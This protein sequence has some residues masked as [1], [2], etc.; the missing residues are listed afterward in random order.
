MAYGRGRKRSSASRG[1]S[2]YSARRTTRRRAPV[3]RRVSRGRVRKSGTARSSVQ[4]VRVVIQTTG[5]PAIGA[6][7]ATLANLGIQPKT[8]KPKTAKIGSN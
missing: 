4:T 3:R 8:V 5:Q 1:R 2:S 7:E 6:Q